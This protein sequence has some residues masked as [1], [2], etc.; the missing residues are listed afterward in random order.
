MAGMVLTQPVHF[1]TGTWT[2]CGLKGIQHRAIRYTRD[3]SRVS[4]RSCRRW[5][6]KKQREEARIA[7]PKRVNDY[8]G[9]NQ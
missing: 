3:A 4:C 8:Q 1:Q 2:A 6:T 9:E 7:Q 5:L